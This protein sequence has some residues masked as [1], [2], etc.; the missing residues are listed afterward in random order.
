MPCQFDEAFFCVDF[1]KKGNR[2]K[3]IDCSIIS[4][5]LTDLL[6]Y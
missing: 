4:Y 6:Q 5:S 3:N 1:K 2:E